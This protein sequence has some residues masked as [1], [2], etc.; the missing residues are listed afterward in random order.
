MWSVLFTLWMSK[1]KDCRSRDNRIS[2][3]FWPYHNEFKI[4]GLWSVYTITGMLPTTWM[5]QCFEAVIRETTYLLIT[6]WLN[7]WGCNFSMKKLT[8]LSVHRSSSCIRT[9]PAPSSPAHRRVCHKLFDILGFKWSVQRVQLLVLLQRR[10]SCET[11]AVTN[12]A[13]KAN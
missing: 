4:N 7:W 9:A 11:P 3:W 6:E 2:L 10:N 12:E 1:K 5:S 8:D 13:E